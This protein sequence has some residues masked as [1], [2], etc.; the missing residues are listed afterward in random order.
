MAPDAA[1]AS[2][3]SANDFRCNSRTATQREAFDRR[4]AGRT[5]SGV[6]NVMM[7]KSFSV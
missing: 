7:S 1:V 2:E 6:Q 3:I 5:T 4:L